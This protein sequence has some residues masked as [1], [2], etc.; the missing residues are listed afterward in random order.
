MQTR[1]GSP[2]EAERLWQ[3]AI[4]NGASR[5]SLCAHNTTHLLSQL[6]GFEGFPVS[7]WPKSAVEAM[8]RVP[9]VKTNRVY[10]DD[11]GKDLKT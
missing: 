1:D 4:A 8:A 7:V 5:S 11:E 3:L 9:G 6:P 10:Q 2:E